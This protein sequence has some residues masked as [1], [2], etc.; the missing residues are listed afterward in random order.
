MDWTS[1][2]SGKACPW[3][4]RTVQPQLAAVTNE[5]PKAVCSGKGVIQAARCPGKKGPW[6]WV[7][8][9]AWGKGRPWLRETSSC[10]CLPFSP[11][12]PVTT[13][14]LVVPRFLEVGTNWSVICTLDGLFPASE[15]QVQLAL[16][17]QT[18]N[19]TVESHG[20][21]TTAT[22]TATASVEQEGTQEIVCNMTLGSDSW[23]T[24]ENLTIYSKRGRS[25]DSKPGEAR[26][27]ASVSR[28]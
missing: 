19:P 11:A 27:G 7:V 21:T 1:R 3:P 13:P 18:L 2:A 28:V 8:S 4:L 23:E 26:G 20:D 9:V 14:H 25:Q 12:L 24:R 5:K 15:V 6:F 16:G 10:S 22:A 17:N